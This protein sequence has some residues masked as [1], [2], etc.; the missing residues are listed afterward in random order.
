MTSEIRQMKPALRL[1]DKSAKNR[2]SDIGMEEI[3]TS[4]SS[5]TYTD[6][7]KTAMEYDNSV[8]FKGVKLICGPHLVI[9]DPSE[10][11]ILVSLNHLMQSIVR[12][13]GF[14]CLFTYIRNPKY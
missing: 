14:N 12:N 6:D 9:I 3:M 5:Q 8:H 13:H 4:L 11:I 2:N 10:A 7:N 1:I